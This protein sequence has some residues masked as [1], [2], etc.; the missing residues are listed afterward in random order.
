MVTFWATFTI[1]NVLNFHLN[2]QFQNVVFA[3]IFKIQKL[4]DVVD[5]LNFQTEL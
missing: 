4:F 1:A 2:K 5:V 3:G